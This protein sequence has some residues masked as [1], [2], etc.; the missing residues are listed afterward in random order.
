[1]PA[2]SFLPEGQPV[3]I[4]FRRLADSDKNLITQKSIEKAIQQFEFF[5]VARQKA[6]YNDDDNNK[7]IDAFGTAFG[8]RGE[9]YEPPIGKRTF[10]ADEYA[11]W[12]IDYIEGI[13]DLNTRGKESRKDGVVDETE[14]TVFVKACS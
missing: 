2:A 3:K 12:L 6:N 4:D 13:Y 7:I 5:E 14:W 1:M 9:W 10:H 8:Y 11:C